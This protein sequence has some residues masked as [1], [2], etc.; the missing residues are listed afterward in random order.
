MS[1]HGQGLYEGRRGLDPGPATPRSQREPAVQGFLAE[2]DEVQA[3]LRARIGGGEA[4]EGWSWGGAT[5][6][7][8]RGT[9]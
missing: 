3:G 1:L 8:R 9:S 6:C 5:G 7:C 4:L 2:Q